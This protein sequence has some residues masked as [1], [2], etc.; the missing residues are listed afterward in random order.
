MSG[1]SGTHWVVVAQ[2]R[3]ALRTT[4]ALAAVGATV[5]IVARTWYV[6][7]D[8]VTAS[9]DPYNWLL[10]VLDYSSTAIMLLPLLVAA[11]VAGP[12]VARELESG[13]YRLAWTQSVSPARWLA[14]RL[15]IP[16]VVVVAGGALLVAL[17]RWTRGAVE[18][19]MFLQLWDKQV[20]AS[21]GT[22]AVA[23]GLLATAFGALGGLLV[24]RTLV[25]MSLAGLATGGV[26]LALA[27]VREH[28]WPMVL[29]VGKG[30][31]NTL[32]NTA[33]DWWVEYG[34][35]SPSGE[36]LYWEDCSAPAPAWCNDESGAYTEFVE[37]HPVSHFWPLQLVETGIVLALAVLVTTVAFR[38]LRRHH[39]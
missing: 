12:L 18:D 29:S 23:Y 37:H 30:M 38:V 19:S 32:T 2:H 10:I 22:V 20:Y 3:R 14:S 35:L 6:T 9:V 5:L 31:P 17:F 34:R 28:L 27:Q 7:A 8:P 11:Y 4:L 33:D 25:A 15:A 16:T 21:S 39:A 13:T 36:R 24:R 26:L 1:L